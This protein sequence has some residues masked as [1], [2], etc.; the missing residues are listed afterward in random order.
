MDVTRFLSVSGIR[1][2]MMPVET[3]PGHINNIYL[4]LDGDLITLFDVGS[5]T[6]MSIEGLERR[7]G[8]VRERFREDVSLEKVQH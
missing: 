6:E 3:F 1:V 5:G 8:E 7:I 2:Y 4:I